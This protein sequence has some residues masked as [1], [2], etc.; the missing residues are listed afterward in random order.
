MKIVYEESKCKRSGEDKCQKNLKALVN[1]TKGCSACNSNAFPPPPLLIRKIITSTFPSLKFPQ[2]FLNV[3]S[4]VTLIVSKIF[5]GRHNCLFLA[6][7]TFHT[8]ARWPL[9]PPLIRCSPGGASNYSWKSMQRPHMFTS[10]KAKTIS[11]IWKS[12]SN[13]WRS[14]LSLSLYNKFWT[15]WIPTCFTNY[16]HFSTKLTMIG[17]WSPGNVQ[18][19]HDQSLHL[20]LRPA[21]S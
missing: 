15:I 14:A 6:T 19:K 13:C 11:P 21:H 1:L 12:F 18:Q 2:F 3:S 20:N 9:C 7:H 8:L 16:E 5:T 4:A 17:Q 10:Q